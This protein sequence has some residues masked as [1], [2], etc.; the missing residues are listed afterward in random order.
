MNPSE[1]LFDAVCRL[2]VSGPLLGTFFSGIGFW[3]T[4]REVLGPSAAH[5]F[6]IMPPALWGAIAVAI[7]VFGH[8]GAWIGKLFY[9]RLAHQG[10]VFYMAVIGLLSVQS[11]LSGAGNPLIVATSAALAR[12]MH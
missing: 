11:L 6:G 8:Y 9:W 7:A 1:K 12:S 2:A 4:P 5:I 10:A 3:L